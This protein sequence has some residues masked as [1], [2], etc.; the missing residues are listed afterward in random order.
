MDLIEKI[1]RI[2]TVTIPKVHRWHKSYGNEPE[3]ELKEGIQLTK[4]GFWRYCP[5]GTLDDLK[6]EFYRKLGVRFPPNLNKELF[7]ADSPYTKSQTF[8]GYINVRPLRVITSQLYVDKQR[9]FE[10]AEEYKCGGYRDKNSVQLSMFGDYLYV[11][12]G[13]HRIALDKILMRRT[14]A[15][16]SLVEWNNG[17]PSVR[18]NRISGN[19][20]Q[21]PER[22]SAVG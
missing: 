7:F 4:F 12:N 2:P 9:L 1:D 8:V 14:F 6:T 19:V 10:L 22:L 21:L 20:Y 11:V 13:T 18:A 17:K 3:Y 16:V 15:Q 5:N